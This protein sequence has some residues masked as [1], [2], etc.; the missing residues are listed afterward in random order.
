MLALQMG[1]V[2]MASM[3]A[4]LFLSQAT[5]LPQYDS[6]VKAI[7]KLARTYTAQMETLK[8]FRSGGEQNVTVKHVHVHDGGQAIVGNVSAREG[9]ASKLEGQPHAKP[10][11]AISNAPQPEM[12]RTLQTDGEPMPQRRHG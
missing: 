10:P 12:R 3:K 2:H 11:A 5:M 1:V 6:A 7:T 9:V 8:K 4:S